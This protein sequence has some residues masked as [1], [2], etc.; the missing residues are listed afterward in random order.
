MNAGHLLSSSST[1]S[2]AWTALGA[3]IIIASERVVG[4]HTRGSQ[5]RGFDLDAPPLPLA[6]PLPLPRPL[7]RPLPPP[8][9][10]SSEVLPSAMSEC[11]AGLALP[12]GDWPCP[13]SAG[14]LVRFLRD[15]FGGGLPTV[16]AACCCVLPLPGGA[17]VLCCSTASCISCCT[18]SYASVDDWLICASCLARPMM[19]WYRRAAG[20]VAC[21]SEVVLS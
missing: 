21:V 5:P 6:L 2:P 19:V 11:C 17:L 13:P 4:S 3:S 8:M 15:R 14:L 20:V 18:A 9:A 1:R 7:P 16:A 12:D 10:G